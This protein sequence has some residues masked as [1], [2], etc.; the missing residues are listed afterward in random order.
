M[1]ATNINIFTREGK[2]I[3]GTPLKVQDYSAL[4]NEDN[5]F[6]DA[7]YNAEYINKDYR[8]IEVETANPV[9]DFTLITGHSASEVLT[10]FCSNDKC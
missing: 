3:A 5:G 10:H 9:S 8:N 4:I 6:L 7:V 2:H 1:L